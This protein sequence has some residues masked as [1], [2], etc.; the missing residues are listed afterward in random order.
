MA[1]HNACAQ[2]CND[3]DVILDLAHAVTE[4]GIGVA[5]ILGAQ[6]FLIQGEDREDLLEHMCPWCFK[7]S[8]WAVA[9]RDEPHAAHADLEPAA[10]G[11]PACPADQAQA[12]ADAAGAGAAGHDAA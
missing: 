2:S 3:L 1:W 12:D 5:D 11:A 7:I 10:A 8:T 6:Q 9:A 4:I